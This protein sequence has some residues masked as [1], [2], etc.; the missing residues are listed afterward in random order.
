MTAGTLTSSPPGEPPA[1][2]RLFRQAIR[3]LRAALLSRP[4]TT[5]MLSRRV[6]PT[7]ATE[8]LAFPA[9]VLRNWAW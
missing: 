6:P 4:P 1:S 8:L 2:F 5:T 3:V 9:V 7:A